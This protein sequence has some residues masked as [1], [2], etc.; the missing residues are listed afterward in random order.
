MGNGK[1]RTDTK[2]I[3]EIEWDLIADW[4]WEVRERG[5]KDNFEVSSYVTGHY[6][7]KRFVNSEH[8]KR[9][10]LVENNELHFGQ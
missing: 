10:N 1:K 7:L 3:R 9:S 5:E 2:D 8:Q 6:T 4:M